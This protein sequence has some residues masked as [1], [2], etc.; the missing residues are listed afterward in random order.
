MLRFT[1]AARIA[2]IVFVSLSAV[3]IVALGGF[4]RSQADRMASVRPPPERIAA[5]VEALEHVASA[6]QRL[7]RDRPDNGRI[8][9]QLAAGV[10]E[11]INRFRRAPPR[12][13][14]GGLCRTT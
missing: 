8:Q 5:I 7:D 1:L 13:R 12:R 4:Y 6:Q 11:T 2:M 10:S 3:W 14:P 9:P